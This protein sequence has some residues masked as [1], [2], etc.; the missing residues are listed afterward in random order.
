[1]I[2]SPDA[3]GSPSAQT[4]TGAA[5]PCRGLPDTHLKTQDSTLPS[6]EWP[7]VRRLGGLVDEWVSFTLP[8]VAVAVS[9]LRLRPAATYRARDLWARTEARMTDT[10]Q[11][12][13]AGKVEDTHA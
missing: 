12:T 1:V 10:L 7:V 13:P 3:V 5:P 2:D 9:E 4:R 11:A 6:L 8:E